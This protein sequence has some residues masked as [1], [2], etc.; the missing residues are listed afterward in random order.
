MSLLKKLLGARRESA[1]QKDG[2]LLFES[3]I[4]DEVI[5]GAVRDVAAFRA[6]PDPAKV[7]Y[8]DEV[9]LQDGWRMSEN[10]K[11][12]ALFP[13][14][15]ALLDSLYGRR[16]RP[17]QTL[18]FTRGTEQTVHAD[19]IHFNSEPFGFMCGV[20]IALEDVGPAQGPLLV[21]PGSQR[22]PEINFKEVGVEADV[23][24]YHHYEKHLDRAIESNRLEKKSFSLGKDRRLFGRPTS[25]TAALPKQT[26]LA[27]VF[28]R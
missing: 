14:V 27:A 1:F 3:R 17:F 20:W 18:N 9:R 23:A 13:A 25:S 8:L 6:N 4:P 16:P 22:L 21:H 2:Y 15:L 10:V 11:R 24:N 28:R 19:S 26:N 5:D 7:S 12:I